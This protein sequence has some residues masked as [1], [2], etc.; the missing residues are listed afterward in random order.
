MS[1]FSVIQAE[2][3]RSDKTIETI[4]I[5]DKKYSKLIYVYN[6]EGVCFRVFNEIL[7]LSKCLQGISYNLLA[8]CTTEN[9]LDDFLQH[10]QVDNNHSINF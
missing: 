9:E 5:T 7:E 6:Y 8:E 1:N 3:L 2:Y 4:L 10:L